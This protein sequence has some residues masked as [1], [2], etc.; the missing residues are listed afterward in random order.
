MQLRLISLVLLFAFPLSTF[1]VIGVSHTLP[2][3][4][5]RY[6]GLRQ[7]S[8]FFAGGDGRLNTVM[9]FAEYA[10]AKGLSLKQ[11][12]NMF[13]ATAEL[14]CN[15][16]QGRNI[17]TAQ[18]VTPREH[19]KK[20][21]VATVGHA[22]HY[23]DCTP[24]A[25]S[26]CVFF[27]VSNPSKKYRIKPGSLKMKPCTGATLDVEDDWAGFELQEDVPGASPYKLPSEDPV[28][29]V[30]QKLLQPSALAENY[31]NA[32]SAFIAEC[33]TTG[34]NL[35]NPKYPQLKMPV[36]TNCASDHGTSGSGQLQNNGDLDNPDFEILAVTAWQNTHSKNGDT[37][38]LSTSRL[39]ASAPVSGDF[40]KA[41]NELANGSSS[42]SN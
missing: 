13:S 40:L 10:K 32:K 30:G 35:M 29:S 3:Q 39:N 14:V 34:T 41:L 12:Q 23:P 28:F 31:H 15:G 8:T 4:H 11:V 19:L 21:L 6:A 2:C 37:F 7:L 24:I 22:F 9:T 38:D 16:S 18:L 17:T 26:S 27:Q 20:N 36:A 1:A 25:P 42:G 5:D 33:E